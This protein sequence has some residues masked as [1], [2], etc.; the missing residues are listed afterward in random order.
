MIKKKIPGM[1]GADYVRA[2]SKDRL[3][4]FLL[5]DG[6]I[7]G[8]LVHGTHMIKEMRNNH[9]LGILETLILGHA[10]LGISLMTANLKGEDQISFKIDCSGPVRGV[11]VEGN[12]VGEVR[13]FLKNPHI[14]LDRPLESFD[15][16]PF[17]GDGYLEVTR[18]PAFAKHPYVGRVKLQ[19][20]N[21]AKDLTNYF[22]ESEQIHTAF[23]LS[24]TFDKEGEVAGAGGLFL[25]AMPDAEEDEIIQLEKTIAGLPSIGEVLPT[26]EKTEDFINLHFQPFLPKIL[27]NRRVEFFCRCRRDTIAHMIAALPPENL[28]EMIANGPF[29]V[30]ICCHNCNTFYSFSREE[31]EQIAAAKKK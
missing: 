28:S 14:P 3:Y 20:G 16:A 12:A 6:K 15:L 18:F 27:A 8:A 1:A 24:I 31:L 4:R 11:S 26:I 21:I 5:A 25:Q 7:R 29:P 19:Y 30:E 13:G 9:Q 22:L 10:Y 17:F 23:N 2:R